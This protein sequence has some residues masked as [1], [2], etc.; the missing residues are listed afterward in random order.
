MMFNF[1]VN[2]HLLLGAGQQRLPAPRKAI[3]GAEVSSCHGPVGTVS[4]QS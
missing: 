3:G 2:Q 4:S 1:E